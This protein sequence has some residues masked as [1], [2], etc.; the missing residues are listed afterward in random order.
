MKDNLRTFVD[1]KNLAILASQFSRHKF[2]WKSKVDDVQI[3]NNKM[4]NLSKVG[5]NL[6]FLLK[7]SPKNTFILLFD[8]KMSK[9]LMHHSLTST[10]CKLFFTDHLIWWI[11]CKRIYNDLIKVTKNLRE[12]ILFSCQRFVKVWPFSQFKQNS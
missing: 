9:N 8:V 12:K 6:I 11:T 2:V 3:S 4:V 7:L 10:L 5:H 1:K